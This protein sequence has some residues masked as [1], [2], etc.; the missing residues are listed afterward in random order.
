MKLYIQPNS[1]WAFAAVESRQ[2]LHTHRQVIKTEGLNCGQRH[3]IGI[4][5]VGIVTNPIRGL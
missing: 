2:G 4:D 3:P 1:E 5:G